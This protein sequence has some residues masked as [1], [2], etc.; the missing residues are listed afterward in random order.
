MTWSEEG[1]IHIIGMKLCRA[2]WREGEQKDTDGSGLL[3]LQ[4]VACPQL[5]YTQDKY[6]IQQSHLELLYVRTIIREY[7]AGW[8]VVTAD[9]LRKILKKS[10]HRYIHALPNIQRVT[11]CGEGALNRGDAE[12]I[13]VDIGLLSGQQVGK[14]QKGREREEVS[15]GV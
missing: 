8:N 3:V 10:D 4:Y 6:Y 12:R 7:S 2:T 11:S 1:P 15:L 14:W 9:V 5:R 13:V